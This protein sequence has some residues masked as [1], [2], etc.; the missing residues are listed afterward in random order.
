MSQTLKSAT[1]CLSSRFMAVKKAADSTMNMGPAMADRFAPGEAGMSC[2]ARPS[3]QRRLEGLDADPVDHLAEALAFLRVLRVKGDDLLDGRDDGI[4]V[5]GADDLLG[6]ARTGAHIAA[7][8][9]RPAV[10]A[11]DQADVPHPR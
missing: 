9:E 2:E 1:A 8:D 5:E 6:D 7:D 11:A 3:G 10:L 4:V